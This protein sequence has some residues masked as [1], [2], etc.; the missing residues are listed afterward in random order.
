MA[1]SYAYLACGNSGLKVVSVQDPANPRE[2]GSTQVDG[3]AT[4]VVVQDTFAIVTDQVGG[5]RIFSVATPENPVEIAS[6]NLPGTAWGVAVQGHHAFVAAGG[7]GLRVVSL[8]NPESPVEVGFCDITG[9]TRSVDVQGNFA[10]LANGGTGVKVVSV[11]DKTNP[12]QVGYFDT[13]HYAWGVTTCDSKVFVADGEGGMLILEYTGP[14]SVED[15][16]NPRIILPR[17]FSLSQ[18]YPNPFNPVTSIQFTV[19]AGISGNTVLVIYDVRGKSVKTLI[20]EKLPAG[21]H[22]VVWDG[23]STSGEKV[24]SGTYLFTLKTGEKSVVR[25]MTVVR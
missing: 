15:P 21:S 3:Y 6:I 7:S 11:V 19:P 9:Y 23:R 10:Y 4:D 16:G 22:T 1:G 13:S 12:E 20:D 2:V 18:N 17:S 24:S 5:L 8:A 25:K 14:V